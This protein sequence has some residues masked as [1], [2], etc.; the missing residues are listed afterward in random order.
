[1]KSPAIVNGQEIVAIVSVHPHGIGI[2]QLFEITTRRFGNGIRF[3]ISFHI[4]LDFD[5]LLTYLESHGQIAIACG[6][7][8]ASFPLAI[9]Q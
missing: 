6:I 4:G 8:F 5:E 7:A 2:S 1:M 9:A 3:H